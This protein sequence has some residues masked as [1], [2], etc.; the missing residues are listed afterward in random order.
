MTKFQRPGTHEYDY[1][2]LGHLAI[3]RALRDANLD[4]CKHVDEMYA[5]YVYGDSVCG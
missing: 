4:Y 1:T 5:G 3:E 2:D